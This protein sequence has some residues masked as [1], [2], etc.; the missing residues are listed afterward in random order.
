M[1]WYVIQTF[2]GREEKLI[3]MMRRIVPRELYGDCFA[4]YHEQLRHRGKENQIHVERI[5]PGYVFVTSDEPDRLFLFLKNVPAMSK[6]MS[7]GEF[8]FLPLE[9]A[10]AR[11]LADIMDEDHVIRLSYVATDGK[12]HISYVAGP[13]EAAIAAGA[14][15]IA[16]YQFRLRYARVRLALAGE[17]KEVRMGIIL[18]DDIRRELAY[19]KV[20]APIRVPEKYRVAARGSTKQSGS[21]APGPCAREMENSSSAVYEPGEEVTVISGALAGLP[22]L[23]CQTKKYGVRLAVHYFGRDMTVEVPPDTIRKR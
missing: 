18:N 16:G 2:T 3:R 1:L 5:F 4:A 12:D 20:E 9:T 11:L 10:E 19:G 13:L 21:I 23:V 6:M 17:E 22:A 14:E 8:Y 15:R 7:D